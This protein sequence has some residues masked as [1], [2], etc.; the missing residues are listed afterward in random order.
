[1]NFNPSGR[2]SIL[3]TGT[4]F[5]FWTLVADF[6]S[7]EAHLD[8]NGRFPILDPNGRFSTFLLVSKIEDRPRGAEFQFR[9]PGAKTKNR[10]SATSVQNLKSFISVQN[11]L[12]I[13]PLIVPSLGN[14][15]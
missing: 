15:C 5:Q 1:M 13:Y 10:K 14:N 9:G 4:G 12:K 7:L 3:D 6:R 11:Q 2:F 8:T